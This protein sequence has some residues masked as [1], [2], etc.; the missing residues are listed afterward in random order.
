MS[1][2]QQTR[3]NLPSTAD[4]LQSMAA[5]VERKRERKGSR[6]IKGEKLLPNCCMFLSFY[7]SGYEL[8]VLVRIAHQR[9]AGSPCSVLLPEYTGAIYLQPRLNHVTAEAKL[10]CLSPPLKNNGAPFLGLDVR[11]NSISLSVLVFFVFF[12]LFFLSSSSAGSLYKVY[13][14]VN[15]FD[16]TPPCC[17]RNKRKQFV[18]DHKYFASRETFFCKAAPAKDCITFFILF[19]GTT[20]SRT[21]ISCFIFAGVRSPRISHDRL[22]F[23]HLIFYYVLIQR[24]IKKG[25]CGGAA[26]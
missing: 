14:R 16:I 19:F 6:Y 7:E 24:R 8:L 23:S 11:L 15:F 2:R 13:R 22:A 9:P 4:P 3:G 26:L 17:S 1:L 10:I 21:F 5:V 18:P 12:C 20:K 25:G